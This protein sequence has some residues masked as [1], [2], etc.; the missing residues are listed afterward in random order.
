MLMSSSRAILPCGKHECPLRCH[1]IADHSKR[2]CTETVQRT[3]ERKHQTKVK[4]SEKDDRCRECLREDLEQERRIK[5]DLQL[6]SDRLSRQMAYRQKLEK[7]EDDIDYQRRQ[8][9]YMKEEEDQKKDLVQKKKDGEKL[10]ATASK[11]REQK[12]NDAKEAAGRAMPHFKHK[13]GA[14]AVGSAEKDWQWLKEHHGDSSEAL[15]EL[16]GMIGLDDVKGEFLSVKNKVDTLLRQK[17]SLP[18]ERFNCSMLGN[19]GTGPLPVHSTVLLILDR[20]NNGGTPLRK[21]PLLGWRHPRR[22][23]QRDHGLGARPWGRSGVQE[24]NRRAA[25]CRRRGVVC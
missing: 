15:D 25:D 1:R 9:Q 20:Q 6:E 17:S 23:L 13:S 18:G 3:C 11:M 4:C 10:L 12:A 8:I 2:K 21:I 5:R 19:P 24:T 16:M 7:L 22:L 14:D